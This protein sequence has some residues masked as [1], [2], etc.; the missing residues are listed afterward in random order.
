MNMIDAT[1]KEV[2]KKP[3]LAYGKYFVKVRAVDMG[4]DFETEIMCNSEKE[5]LDIKKGHEFDH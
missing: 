5:A 3:R 2:L 4:G 1:V